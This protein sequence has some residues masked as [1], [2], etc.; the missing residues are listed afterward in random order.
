MTSY[1]ALVKLLCRSCCIKKAVVL[2]CTTLLWCSGC[3][4]AG[5]CNGGAVP[6]VP[7]LNGMTG[8]E[9]YASA[10]DRLRVLG[11]PLTHKQAN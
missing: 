8:V 3:P 1:S 2:Y 7:I 5:C 9:A 10:A 6:W 4:A 11:A